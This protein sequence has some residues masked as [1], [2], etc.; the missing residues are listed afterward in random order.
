M[1]RQKFKLNGNYEQNERNTFEIFKQQ[2][3]V[4]DPLPI[5]I[6]I[7]IYVAMVVLFL[8][9]YASLLSFPTPLLAVDE[10]SNEV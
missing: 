10:V 5:W 1:V 9:S 4:Y 6:L 3:P 7:V 8:L 2:F